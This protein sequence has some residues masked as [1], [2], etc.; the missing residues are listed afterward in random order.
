[1]DQ[2]VN[3]AQ[4]QKM[5]IVHVFRFKLTMKI[6]FLLLATSLL[7]FSPALVSAAPMKLADYMALSGPA[8]L[9]RVAYGPAPSQYAELFVP[10][11]AGP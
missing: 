6:R 11:G 10:P 2:V 8:P 7:T 9:A 1:M 4:R 5:R 3:R